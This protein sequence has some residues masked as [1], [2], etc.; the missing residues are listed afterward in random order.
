MG[1]S[2]QE[3]QRRPKIYVYTDFSGHRFS[4]TPNHVVDFENPIF[5]IPITCVRVVYF[6][7]EPDCEETDFLRGSREKFLLKSAIAR[8]EYTKRQRAKYCT[9]QG[10]VQRRWLAR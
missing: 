3:V 9:M 5:T 8:Y 2:E 6:F 4:W 10:E 7:E 1:L